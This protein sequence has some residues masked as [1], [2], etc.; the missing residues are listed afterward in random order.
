MSLV[1]IWPVWN[2]NR[3]LMKGINALFTV[4]IW[5]VWN[6]NWEWRRLL[7][8]PVWSSSDLC[9]VWTYWTHKRFPEV[10]E[11]LSDL[12]GVWTRYQ[13]KHLRTEKKVLIWPEWSVNA[14]YC[15]ASKYAERVPIW[16]GWNLN[17]FFGFAGIATATV[18]IWPVWNVN[19][20]QTM[21]TCGLALSRILC[22][23]LMQPYSKPPFLETLV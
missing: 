4:S 14:W 11:S 1:L 8:L 2:V 23:A 20:I 15:C 10:S 21:G 7:S 17:T 6:L 3:L 22:K 9:G 12:S 16:P 13:G 18:L 19:D 5:P